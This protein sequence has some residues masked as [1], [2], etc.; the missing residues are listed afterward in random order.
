MFRKEAGRQMQKSAGVPSSAVSRNQTR[1][2]QGVAPVERELE[3]VEDSV[4]FHSLL[5]TVSGGRAGDDTGRDSATESGQ[6]DLNISSVIAR[7]QDEGPAM[8]GQSRKTSQVVEQQAGR[9][10]EK[11]KPSRTVEPG[12]PGK[13]ERNLSP[14]A[15]D[16]ARLARAAAE[17]VVASRL[18]RQEVEKPGWTG[19][20]LPAFLLCLLAGGGYV[21]HETGNEL[22]LAKAN[23]TQL[24][25]RLFKAEES[26]SGLRRQ[27]SGDAGRIQTLVTPGQLQQEMAAYRQEMQKEIYGYLDLMSIANGQFPAASPE[28]QVSNQSGKTDVG[29]VES[30]SLNKPLPAPPGTRVVMEGKTGMTRRGEWDVYLVSFGTEGKAR[31]NLER[32]HRD[33]PEAI[34]QPAR[35]KGKDVYRIAVPGFA[36]RKD[37]S[38][39]LAEI[40]AKLGLKG[41]WIGR[42]VADR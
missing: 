22:S 27:V 26:L 14:T 4:D 33:V 25:A 41:S 19:R 5:N 11:H 32:Y 29:P 31:E 18:D 42:H 1:Q 34:I 15:D 10:P 16:V 2:D 17:E 13:R 37:A 20:L 9:H 23:I 12:A 36:T 6:K 39:Y 21:Y 3:M 38:R 40:R 30:E 28:E 24:S 8:Q 35:V 7:I